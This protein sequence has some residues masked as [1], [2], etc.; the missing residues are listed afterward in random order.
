MKKIVAL[1]TA[2]T[3][4]FATIAAAEEPASVPA[5]PDATFVMSTQD[6]SADMSGG[7]GEMI[8]PLII[9]AILAIAATEG[10]ICKC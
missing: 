2:L 6:M 1:G 3:L 4:G 5:T 9:V 8:I 10:S 7:G